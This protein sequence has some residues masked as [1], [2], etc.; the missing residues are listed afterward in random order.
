MNNTITVIIPVYNKESMVLSC[1]SSLDNQTR[2]PDKIIIINDGSDDQSLSKIISHS[3]SSKKSYEVVTIKNSGVSVARNLGIKLSNSEYVAF[4]DADDEWDNRYLENMDSL[5]SDYPHCVAYSCSHRVRSINGIK[6]IN[7]YYG[8]GFR[9]IVKDYCKA[10]I[11]SSIIN[12]SKVIVKRSSLYEI[13]L[14]PENERNGE[15]LYVWMKLSQIGNI[16]YT[17]ETLVTIN[18]FEDL[19]RVL[20]RGC[21]PYPLKYFAINDA[22]LTK[23]EIKYLF[24]LALKNQIINLASDDKD[25]CTK[26]LK[27]SKKI[28]FKHYI[29][30]FILS[31]F[32]KC[33]FRKI[34]RHKT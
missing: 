16:A 27:F 33:I 25:S 5:I 29:V 13:G 22:A 28:D 31:K 3:Q 30:L 12:S 6:D 19:S 26:I 23:N 2:Q 1:L 21:I 11:K 24:I 4:L 10:S 32:P 20:R 7:S 34:I 8:Q 9:G 18:Q 14:F 17:A 15:D